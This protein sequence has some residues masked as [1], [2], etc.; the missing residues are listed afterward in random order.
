MLGAGYDPPW[1]TRSTATAS[2]IDER[3]EPGSL[4]SSSTRRLLQ[5]RMRALDDVVRSRRRTSRSV[6]II[7]L[8]GLGANDFSTRPL[9]WYLARIGHRVVGWELG[10]HRLPVDTALKR[11]IP[12]LASVAEANGEPVTLVG[13]SLGGIVAREAARRRP[14]LVAQVITLGSPLGWSSSRGDGDRHRRRITVPVTSIFSKRDRV[15]NWRG[16][17]D[18]TTPGA[19]NIEVTSGHA[20]LGLDPAVWRI[21]ADTI[22]AGVTSGPTVEAASDVNQDSCSGVLDP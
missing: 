9:R 10:T 15:V 3:S 1:G 5:E 12:R 17:I 11:F 19:R 6:P 14:E 21:V 7:V 13:W 20:G 22:G 2:E 4:R 8:P 18:R 16:S